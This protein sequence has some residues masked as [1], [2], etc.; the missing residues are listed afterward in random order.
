MDVGCHLQRNMHS[1]C[2]LCDKEAIVVFDGYGKSSTKDM[3]HQRRAKGQA[4]VTVTF[5]EDMKLTMKK[6]NFLANCTNKQLFINLLG[7]YLEKKCK[8]FHAP[9]DTDVLIVEKTVESALLKD[10]ALVGEDTDLLILCYH[11]TLDSHNIFFRP[12]LKK[13]VKKPKVWNIQAVKVQLGPE[14]CSNI[15][16]LHVVLGCDTT[17]HLYGIGKGTALKKFK[18][19][20][21]FREQATVFSKESANCEKV[22]IAGERALVMLYLGRIS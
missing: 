21:L 12:E 8:V 22:C 19:N 2:R 18:L 10:T 3:V 20:P 17:Y 4:G 9:G 13:N 16:F 1:V 11:A 15:L 14:I 6:V 7:S 5:S